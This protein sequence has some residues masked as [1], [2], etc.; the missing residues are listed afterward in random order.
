VNKK[1]SVENKEE[2]N[3][4]EHLFPGP[5]EG[6]VFLAGKND[7]EWAACDFSSLFLPTGGSSLFLLLAAPPFSFLLAACACW[8][9]VP[10]PLQ[11]WATLEPKILVILSLYS[12]L[13][14][15]TY[16]SDI[17]IALES[18][19][20]VILVFFSIFGHIYQ[21][22]QILKYLFDATHCNFI[23]IYIYIYIRHINL[24]FCC[25]IRI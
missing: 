7:V 8:R 15:V 4:P 14:L 2:V 13:F 3:G 9:L 5:R 1:H 20:L 21:I 24:R 16:I 17:S 23:A 25:N 19:I 18:K 6:V 12:F 10:D 22:Y 11:V